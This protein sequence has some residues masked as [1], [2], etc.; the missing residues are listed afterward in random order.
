MSTSA[1]ALL[2]PEMRAVLERLAAEGPQP[3][4]TTLP[5][6]EGR[7]LSERA[8][9][10]W[11]NGTPA[12]AD[13]RKIP[14]STGIDA[15]VYLPQNDR[16]GEAILYVHGGGF[17][18]CSAT[19]HDGAA[20]QLARDCGAAVVTFDYR[21]APEHPYPAGLED[22][23]AIWKARH[24]ILQNRRWSVSG[25]SAGANL[26]V[27]MMLRLDG[28]DL[29][30]TGLLFYG[31]YD[32][33]F[34]S[35]S[36]RAVA[37]GPGLTRD[38]MRRYWDFYTPQAGRSQDPFLTPVNAPD[39]MLAQLPPLYLNAAQIDPLC[40]DSARF[41]A[42]LHAL[43]RHDEF[44]IIAGVVHGFM[45]MSLELPQSVQAFRRA[46]EVFQHMLDQADGT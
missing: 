18:F 43:G 20:R 1:A 25:D 5:P 31:V 4:P 21:L 36:Y 17:A 29:P 45:Q 40:S 8:N 11:N 37:D 35:P 44:E 46:G 24:E 12:M 23:L 26:A 30:A 10:R 39:E 33:D 22:C 19:T 9:E 14:T 7:A 42:R 13:I 3:D 15:H 27:A 6:A 34:T 16:G 41:A 2:A 32:A 38:K 28:Q